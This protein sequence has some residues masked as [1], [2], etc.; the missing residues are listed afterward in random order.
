MYANIGS[1]ATSFMHISFPGAI[2]PFP[3]ASD[4]CQVYIVDFI[5]WPIFDF[6]AQEMANTINKRFKNV[7]FD[8]VLPVPMHIKKLRKRGF[9]QSEM[10]ARNVSEKLG[11]PYEN[12]L[13]FQG[14]C[15]KS[16]HTLKYKQRLVNVKDAYK[17]ANVPNDYK[18]VL[19]VDD[20][21]TSG[22]TIN[23]CAK[24]L[25]INGVQNVYCITVAKR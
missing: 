6:F 23:E 16:Q 19:L 15:T 5:F 24:K 11:V 18:T 1:Y 14:K 12:K 3:A 25:R 13:L 20:V 21:L 22:A 8:A 9:N 2:V 4:I 17:V 10:L 7:E